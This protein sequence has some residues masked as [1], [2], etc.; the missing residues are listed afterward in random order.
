MGQYKKALINLARRSFK[1]RIVQDWNEEDHPRDP[2]GKFGTGGGGGGS[3]EGS[4]SKSGVTEH[5]VTRKASGNGAF[6]HGTLKVGGKNVSYQVK[7]FE[8]GSRFGIDGG[9]V[10]KLFAQ[11]PDGKSLFEYDR[12]WVKKP[13]TKEAKQAL[14]YLKKQYNNRGE[15][16]GG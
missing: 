3:S 9:S 8:T 10:S 2:D 1:R 16:M 15:N 4:G 13:R 5:K 12:E 6:E 14:E 7:A 11:G